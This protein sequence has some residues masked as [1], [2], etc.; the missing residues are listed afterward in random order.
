MDVE[1]AWFDLHFFF[2]FLMVMATAQNGFNFDEV[3]SVC[4]LLLVPLVLH[5]GNGRLI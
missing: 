5:P 4:P 3:Q 1:W 2:S